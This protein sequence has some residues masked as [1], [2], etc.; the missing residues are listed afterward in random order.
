MLS[1]LEGVQIQTLAISLWILWTLTFG[2]HIEKC[3]WFKDL[4]VALA[5]F[6][7]WHFYRDTVLVLIFFILI[8]FAYLN[9]R[10]SAVVGVCRRAGTIAI[11]RRWSDTVCSFIWLAVLFNRSCH[12]TLSSLLSSSHESSNIDIKIDSCLHLDH[13]SFRHSTRS[14]TRHTGSP[15]SF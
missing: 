2:V 13:A 9:L 8:F 14:F 4:L 12:F 1:P 11:F 10:L 5:F 15:S 3:P 6:Q 7:I